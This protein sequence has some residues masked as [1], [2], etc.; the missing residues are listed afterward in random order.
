MTI[1]SFKFHLRARNLSPRTI[2]ATED[3]LRPF[4]AICDP[5]EATQRNVEAY[6]AD[7]TTR[8]T[9][10]TVLTAW[11]HLR[12]FLPHRSAV[13]QCVDESLPSRQ[14]PGRYNSAHDIA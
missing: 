6:L 10:A 14:S 5:L 4:L 11:R 2:K 8:C 7:M 3:D 12:T 13:N 9:P 1:E